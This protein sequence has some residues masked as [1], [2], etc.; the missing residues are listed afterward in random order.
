MLDLEVDPKRSWA[1]DNRA[2]FPVDINQA[3]RELLLRVPGLG[4]RSVK[5]LLATR[6][7]KTIRLNDLERLRVS[8][9]KIRPFI[10]TPDWRPVKLIDRMDLRSLFAPP[11]QQLSL[12]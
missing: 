2:V 12:L 3:P 4:P 6:R 5:L 1:L 11:P 8:L 10:T 9:R 7:H